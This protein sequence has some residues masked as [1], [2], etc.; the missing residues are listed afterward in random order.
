MIRSS[1]KK[2]QENL[3]KWRESIWEHGERPTVRESYLRWH[4]DFF[5]NFYEKPETREANLLDVGCGYMLSNF[6]KS[7]KLD[8]L[9]DS[10]SAKYHGVDP[11]D[12]W[13]KLEKESKR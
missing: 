4:S 6:E 8:Y 3:I 13:F 12:S 1:W 5:D 10:L 11:E 9:F 2:R 7:G